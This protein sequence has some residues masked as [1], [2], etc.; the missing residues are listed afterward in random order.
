MTLARYVVRRT[1]YTL[2]LLFLIASFNFW[3]FELIPGGPLQFLTG[4]IKSAA[5]LQTYIQFYGLDKPYW[6][7]FART[8]YNTF[9]FSFIFNPHFTSFVSQRPVVDEIAWRLP[10]TLALLGTATVIELI[11]GVVL[12]TY[13]GSRRG[14]K[15]DIV[16]LSTSL[17]TQSVPTFWIGI[18][19]IYIFGYTL[20]LFP[21]GG[22]ADVNAPTDFIGYS[23]N[24]AWHAV[25]PVTTLVIFLFG[26]TLLTM[27][28]V[29]IDIMTEDYILTARAKG[30]A[31]RA[32]IFRHALRNA[33]LPLVTIVA[34][35]LS[36]I[37]AG[38]IIT[39]TVFSWPGIGIY[40]LNSAVNADFPTM[41]VLFFVIAFATII[42]NFAA[43]VLY[44]FL[45]P[46]VRV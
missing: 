42:G 44:A 1:I 36:G 25:L 45:D 22:I 14:S 33:T 40:L 16:S 27:R 26:G 23:L 15:F 20:G 19:L 31:E 37:F 24:V 35:S 8:V 2:L 5:Q 30:L 41:N 29:L 3:L 18:I 12:G 7:Q 6:E 9:T 13:A 4:N 39:E 43:D 28:S 21:L 46:R 34:L 10:N 32:V 17:V 38:A 11:I